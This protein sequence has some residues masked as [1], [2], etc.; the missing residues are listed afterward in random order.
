LD[1]PDPAPPATYLD[2]ATVKSSLSIVQRT[3]GSPESLYRRVM[4]AIL[5]YVFPSHDHYFV[6][7]ENLADRLHPNFTVHR[8]LSRPGGGVHQFDFL[9]GETK[10]PGETWATLE[11][12]LHTVCQ[13]SN[14]ETN[15]VY[16]M[17]QI[18]L[19]VQFYKHGGGVFQR[20]S[21]RLHLVNDVN[22]VNHWLAFVK[23]NPL[24]LV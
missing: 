12:H 23:A 13:N 18:G 5:N 1:D 2:I 17:L 15:N 19:E 14:N 8:I 24:P 6:T 20:I 7:R 3:P 11:E 16:G 4:L 9:L 21:N 10:V 22:D